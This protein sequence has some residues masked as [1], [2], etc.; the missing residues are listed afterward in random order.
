MLE[1]ASEHAPGRLV[2]DLPIA[3]GL[4][5]YTGTVYERSRIGHDDLG[6]VCSGGRYD[7]LASCGAD[8]LPG[9]GAVDRRDA[10]A[11]AGLSRGRW[12]AAV[13]PSD[14]RRSSRC[15][16]RSGRA[17]CDRVAAALRPRG[18]P[19]EVAPTAAKYGKQIRY[20]D[21]RGIPFV[22][23]P[24]DDG[25]ARGPRHPLGEQAAADPAT[26]EPPAG[27]PPPRAG[28]R[29]GHAGGMTPARPG[30]LPT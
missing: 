6:S 12:C 3:R 30:R 17:E 14:L 25:G 5:Y 11:V 28:R 1:T 8:V 29:R 9:R 16:P 22:W 20:A 26:W 19:V 10:A 15:R 24:P 23:F 27:D 13:A 18:V 4:D 21:R 2:A 7:N